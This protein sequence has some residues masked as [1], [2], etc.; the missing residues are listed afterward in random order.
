MR[1]T[2]F[3]AGFA[4]AGMI[5][6]T[7]MAAGTRG[8]GQAMDFTYLQINGMDREIKPE[9]SD[10][11]LV[12]KLKTGPGYG[13]SGSYAFS[14]KYFLFGD[15]ADSKSD[16][17]YLSST[18]LPLSELPADTR[19][20]R[21]DLGVG[22]DRPVSSR[23]DVVARV[24]YSSVDYGKFR[25][26]KGDDNLIYPPLSA[27]TGDR[28][29]TGYLVD[30]GVRSELTHNIQGSL[31]ARYL[32]VGTIKSTDLIGSLLFE[33]SPN[34]GIDVGVDAGSNIAT[35]QVGVRFTP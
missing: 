35:Y 17:D 26:G 31:G 33:V 8:E 15:Y 25:V 30:A 6:L 13:L 19:V 12:H 9:S 28:T 2:V 3:L 34:W 5:P 11:T 27:E 21:Y 7:S 24:A 1:T 23:L 16:V 18:T 10:Q 4:V 32:D 22:T 20:K 14:P 29:S